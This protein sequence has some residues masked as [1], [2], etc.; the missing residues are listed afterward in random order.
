MALGHEVVVA[1]DPH[2]R[3]GRPGLEPR[4]E[5]VLQP[6]VLVGGGVVVERA[7]VAPH[8]EQVAGWGLRQEPVQVRDGGDAHRGRVT[9]PSARL[10][11]RGRLGLLARPEQLVPGARR[12]PDHVAREL[13]LVLGHAA[14]RAQELGPG[15]VL[16]VEPG[17]YVD[18]EDT[19]APPELRGLGIRI[20]DDL[21]VTETGHENLTARIP[22]T[23]RDVESAGFC[24]E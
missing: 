3:A 6:A 20:E 4:G 1:G 2:H 23:V 22:R 11:H 21:L 14:S 19:A 24:E 9:A 5:G 8:E 15:I 12:Q 10:A 7:Q 13:E 16:T 17:L 18:P